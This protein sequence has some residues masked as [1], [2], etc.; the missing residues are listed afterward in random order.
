MPAVTVRLPRLLSDLL[1]GTRSERVEAVDVA[2]ALAM[3]C[4]RHPEL[5]VHL[6]DE[7]GRLRPHVT[8]LLNGEVTRDALDR[9]L[10]EGDEVTVMQAVSG[11]A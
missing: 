8:C 1:G 6:F 5:S 9:G 2:G 11:G 4:Q 3:L 10:A 7:T